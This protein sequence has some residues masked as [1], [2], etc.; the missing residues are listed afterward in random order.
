MWNKEQCCVAGK[1]CVLKC[2]TVQISHPF[3]LSKRSSE[4]LCMFRISSLVRVRQKLLRRAIFH[5]SWEAWFVFRLVWHNMKPTR[6]STDFIFIFCNQTQRFWLKLTMHFNAKPIKRQWQ[7]IICAQCL[8]SAQCNKLIAKHTSCTK[9][10]FIICIWM[11]YTSV[12]ITDSNVEH[13]LVIQRSITSMDRYSQAICVQTTSSV[14]TVEHVR[15]CKSQMTS[16]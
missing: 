14:S 6:T 7:G 1:S 3:M 8:H 11:Q 13:S 12:T 16:V 5:S 2:W 10:F 9:T 15:T 4:T